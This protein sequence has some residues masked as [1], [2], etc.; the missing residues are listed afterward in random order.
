MTLLAVC[1]SWGCSDFIVVIL[2]YHQ[3]GFAMNHASDVVS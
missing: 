2:L 1:L 3:L